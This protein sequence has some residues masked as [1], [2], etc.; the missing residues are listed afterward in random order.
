MSRRR[1]GSARATPKARPDQAS[2]ATAPTQLA[3]FSLS[4]WFS[5][6]GL[7]SILLLAVVGALLL[8]RL[9]AASL[10]L[11]EGLLTMQF[12]QGVVDV[13]DASPYFE[14]VAADDSSYMERLLERIAS[15]PDV[16]RANL[17]SRERKILWSSDH[18]LIGR[19]F[20]DAPNREL[21]AAL[22]GRLEIHQE[23][24]HSSEPE[25]AEHSN[26]RAGSN[27][28]VEIYVPVHD[29]ARTRVVG[30][31]E[32]YRAPGLL[33]DTI[34]SGIRIIWAGAI[35]AG[36]LLY[37]G[38]LPLIR[39]AESLIRKQQAQIVE[40]ETIAAV[41]D[42]GS[43][44]AHGIRNPLAVIRSSAEIARDGNDAR[45]A[46]EAASD[47]MEQ[48][49]RLEH[50]VRG[51]LTYVHLPNGDSDPVDLGPL[52]RACLAQFALEM[53]RHG[54]DAS[55]AFPGDLPPVFG[56]SILLGQVINSL[57]ANAI[58]AM[59][60]GGHL[61]LVGSIGAGDRVVLR[62]TDTGVGMS[63][64]QLEKA[65]K[66]FHTTKSQGLGIGLPLAKRILG[67]MGA[68]IGLTSGPGDGTTVE[69]Q[70]PVV[71]R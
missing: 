66:P 30:V 59:P 39:V 25:K 35:G 5:T 31:V 29:R 38:L 32:L 58:E 27:S 55:E 20:A 26:L 63:Q 21:S 42:L 54:I 51:L 11:Q 6:V 65:F 24:R 48:V 53:R 56:D 40:A 2:S 9:F 50:W 49:D 8:S 64:E 70:F 14:S 41:G 44:V 68:S 12:V 4:R 10:L 67:R 19:S 60:S 1:G 52:V 62:I 46:R 36:V 22:D 7:L 43:A 34:A 16:L 57:V 17:Y 23:E 33:Q 45:V 18:S 61:R 28:F 13:E 3:P 47:I 37:L 71:A 69:L 15:S